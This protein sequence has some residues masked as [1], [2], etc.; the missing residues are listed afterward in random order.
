ML[1]I[2]SC[3]SDPNFNNQI[4]I[5][6]AMPIL[7]SPVRLDRNMEPIAIIEVINSKGISGLSSTN[8]ASLKQV[9]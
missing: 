2:T 7:V 4:D 9:I 1:N 3:Q 8:K 5:D 6:T